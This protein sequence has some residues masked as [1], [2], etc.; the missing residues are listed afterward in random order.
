MTD[1]KRTSGIEGLGPLPKF[2]QQE[3]DDFVR[4]R[5]LIG[6]VVAHYSALIHEESDTAA[7]ARLTQEQRKYWT[8]MQRLSVRDHAE[9]RRVL[10]EYPEFLRRAREAGQ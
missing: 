10:A 8:Q 6:A 3:S 5:D 2:T 7:V 4:A 1:E 9:I